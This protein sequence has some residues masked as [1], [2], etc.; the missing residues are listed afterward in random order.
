MRLPRMMRFWALVSAVWVGTV[1][2]S[3]APS[4][5]NH[6]IFADSFSY[7]YGEFA[8]DQRDEF[9]ALTAPAL[10]LVVVE[11]GSPAAIDVEGRRFEFRQPVTNV[12][13]DGVLDVPAEVIAKND[14]RSYAV[15]YLD[16]LRSDF[17]SLL[18]FAA[19][20]AF[21]PPLMV[22]GAGLTNRRRA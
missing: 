14:M 8:N 7:R 19:S 13:Y 20:L 22:L 4:I 11:A 3:T 2:V 12:K 15:I 16:H 6:A 17:H 1:L 10:P 18:M 21:L 5:W 9:E